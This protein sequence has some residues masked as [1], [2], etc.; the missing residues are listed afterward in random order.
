MKKNLFLNIIRYLQL[1]K[2][3][4]KSESFENKKMLQ[5]YTKMINNHDTTDEEKD[6]ANK[7]FKELLK[8]TGLGFVIFLPFSIVTLPLI[9]RLGKYFKIDI[10]PTWYKNKDN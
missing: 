2:K 5:I 1:I 7:Q 4:L 10:L 6:F 8:T 3:G 9:I